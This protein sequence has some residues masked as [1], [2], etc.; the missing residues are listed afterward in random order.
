[1]F[2]LFIR[3][4]MIL[5]QYKL[6]KDGSY[7]GEI[8]GVQGVWANARTLEKCREELQEILEDW[9]LIKIRSREHVPG[10]RIAFDR[11]RMVRYA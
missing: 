2:S 7:F 10:L 8:P 9:T 4:K 6:L 5:A 11:R 3:K 1:M